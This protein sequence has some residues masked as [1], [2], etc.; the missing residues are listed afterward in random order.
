MDGCHHVSCAHRGGRRG[1]ERCGRACGDQR[2]LGR[3]IQSGDP[4][5]GAECEASCPGAGMVAA[6]NAA[7]GLR[8]AAI[9][10]QGERTGGRTPVALVRKSHTQMGST[11]DPPV[12]SGDSPLGR[13]GARKHSIS[14]E[15]RTRRSVSSGQWPD[16]TGRWPVLPKKYEMSGLVVKRADDFLQSAPAAGFVGIQQG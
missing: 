9:V 5:G 12:P 11:G 4:L 16:E 3:P 8:C 2:C 7:D 10:T 6:R 14:V 13:E 15:H 1:E